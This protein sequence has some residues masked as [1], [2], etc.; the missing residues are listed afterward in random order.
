LYVTY[1]YVLKLKNVGNFATQ[2]VWLLT[3]KYAT[4]KLIS[5]SGKQMLYSQDLAI[6]GCQDHLESRCV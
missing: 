1:F 4:E 6:S 2:V 3:M 5:A